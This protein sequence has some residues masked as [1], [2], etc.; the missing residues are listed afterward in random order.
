[1]SKNRRTRAEADRAERREDKK[2][3][4]AVLVQRWMTIG[5]VIKR[6]IPWAGA[7][8]IVYFG[9]Y[10]TSEA[11]AGKVTIAD[12]AHSFIAHLT[13]DRW[14]AY[15]FGGGGIGYGL[16]QRSLR[17][18]TVA[19]MHRR[20]KELEERLDPNRS[21]STLTPQGNTNPKDLI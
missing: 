21:T 19:R 5:A 15:I 4:A 11:L 9:V 1:V 20:Q 13:A 2:L 8:L 17:K 14:V 16:M 3:R 18:S 6:L 10:R 12:I 7:V